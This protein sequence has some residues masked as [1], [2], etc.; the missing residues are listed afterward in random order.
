MSEPHFIHRKEECLDRAA[1]SNTD[2]RLLASHS[3]MEVM[4]QKIAQ[5]S[6]F[7]LDSGEEWQGFEFI[8]LLEG[9]MEYKNSD[10]PVVLEPGDYL[11]RNNVMEE[12]WFE[13]K[14]DVTVLYTSN[15]PAFYLLREEINDYLQLARS[16]ESAEHMDGHSK[17]LV[18]MSYEVGRRLNLSTDRLADLKYAAF[19][20]D[21]G[22]AKVSDEILE[23]EGKLSD[24]EWSVMRKHTIWGREMLEDTDFLK[25]AGKIVEQTHE[26]IDGNGYPKGLEG[27]DITLEAMIISVV[28]AWDAMRTDRP[29]RKALPEKVAIQELKDNSGT[30]FDPGVV[31]AFLCALRDREVAAPSVT[32][33][34]EYK[35]EVIYNKQRK[36][37]LDLSKNIAGL[38]S[39]SE[40]ASSILEA[41]TEATSFQRASLYLFERPFDPAAP[42]K[43]NPHFQK[44]RDV[45]ERTDSESPSEGL[46]LNFEHFHEEYRLGDSYYVPTDKE[47]RAEEAYRL[48]QR[49]SDENFV[50]WVA[51]DLLHVPLFQ[52][53]KIIGSITVDGPKDG[54]PPDIDSIRSLESFASLASMG[55][56]NLYGDVED[57][58]RH[59]ESGC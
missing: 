6:T 33:R 56:Q 11:V 58:V 31:E 3:S 53:E 30:Q 12:S 47:E 21:L 16:I 50:Q 44:H 1:K 32:K 8:Y 46:E 19:F 2:I 13:T 29:Y 59:K 37:L 52:R 34:D 23:K 39:A 35:E 5:G 20:H 48:K 57:E 14:S 45:T 15:Q 54:K 49:L 55:V 28:D 17:R 51:G 42:E 43:V 27:Q 4:K 9:E 25:R 18:R 26:R 10:P 22:K 40:L 24:E 41:V 7:Y 36:Q 38:E